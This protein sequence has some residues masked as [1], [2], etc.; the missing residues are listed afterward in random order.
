MYGFSIVAPR[1]FGGFKVVFIFSTGNTAVLVKWGHGSTQTFLGQ[2]SV[3]QN[4][5]FKGLSTVFDNE[6]FLNCA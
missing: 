6:I 4:L 3:F 2:I 5:D 1:F